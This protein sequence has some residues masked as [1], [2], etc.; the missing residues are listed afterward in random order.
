MKLNLGDA[1]ERTENLKS[2]FFHVVKGN[3]KIL[4]IFDSIAQS[5]EQ[6]GLVGQQICSHTIT[7]DKGVGVCTMML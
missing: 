1:W 4:K 5:I 7:S 2:S 6:V 3:G